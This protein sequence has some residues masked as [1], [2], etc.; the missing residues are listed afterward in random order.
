MDFHEALR[1]AGLT[2]AVCK[3]T[4]FIDDENDSFQTCAD[5]GTQVH[6]RIEELNTHDNEIGG[7]NRKR[8]ASR[9]PDAIRQVVP[10]ADADPRPSA[11]VAFEAFQCVLQALLDALV[12]RC[13]CDAEVVTE[14]RTLWFRLVPLCTE[15]HV[16]TDGNE[17]PRMQRVPTIAAGGKRQITLGST[18]ALALCHLGCLQRALPVRVED[19]LAWGRADL[20]PLLT[21]HLGLPARLQSAARWLPFAASLACW[22]C[23]PGGAIARRPAP[24]S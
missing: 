18:L 2:C 15:V 10:D 3:G 8:K 20:L 5:C 16:S 19:L 9:R 24:A 23:R 21:A 11:E 17:W 14:V 1:P 6:G 22:K 13:G 4:D 12:A 7:S